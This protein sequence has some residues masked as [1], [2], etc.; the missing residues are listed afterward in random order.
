MKEIIPKSNIF[1]LSR[2]IYIF[3]KLINRFT[4]LH[5]I[6]F[7]TFIKDIFKNGTKICLV[8]LDLSEIQ[9]LDSTFMGTLVYVN[10]KSN[11]YKKIFKII[12]PSKEA[13]ENLRSLGLEKILKIEKR[14]EIY[15]K[16]E[17]K[18]YLCYNEQKNKIFKSILKSHILLSNI[19]KDNKKEFCSLIQRLKQEIHNHN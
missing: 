7:K 10:K 8:Y 12:N 17:M 2:D 1:Y 5:A 4:A 13:L 9:Y 11:E 6:S 14:E 18:E 3:I 15:K 19:N 16:N